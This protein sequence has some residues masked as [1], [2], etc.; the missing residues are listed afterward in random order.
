LSPIVVVPK[1]IGKLRICIDFKKLNVAIKKD[2]YPK[3]FTY[4]VPNTLVRCE[5]YSFLDGYLGYHQIF[6]ALKDN[7]RLHLLQTRGL[8]YGR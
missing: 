4:E 8:L 1:T 2:P 7:T 3:P 6:I 5:A